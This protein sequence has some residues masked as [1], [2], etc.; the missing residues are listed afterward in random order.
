MSPRGGSRPGAGRPKGTGTG[1]ATAVMI[2][3]DAAELAEID[4]AIAPGETRSKF[5]TAHALRAA[6]RLSKKGGGR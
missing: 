1:R 4:A 2:R 3:V 5:F 6:R